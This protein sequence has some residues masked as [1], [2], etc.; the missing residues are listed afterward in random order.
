MNAL[1]ASPP[2]LV[3]HQHWRQGVDLAGHQRWGEAA[4]AFAR[5]T[6]VAP[7]DRV[8]WLNLANALR[9]SGALAR[10]V[11]AA[12]RCLQLEPGDP[13]ALRLVAECMAGMHR[14]AESVEAFALLDAGGN[15]DPETMVNHASAL[16]A[17]QQ[18]GEAAKVLLRALT[19]Q[20]ALVPAHLLLADACREQGLKREAV[21]CMKTVLALEPSNIQALANLSYEKRHLCDWHDYEQD[22]ERLR[23]DLLCAPVGLARIVSVFGL[24]SLPLPPDLQLV[25]ARGE[26]QAQAAGVRALPPVKPWVAGQ[27]RVRLGWLSYDFRD[28]PVSQLLHEM[29]ATIDRA[30]FEVVLYSIGPGDGSA[31]RAR[32]K[33]AADRFIDLGDVSDARAA[34]RI[35]SDGIDLLIDLMGHTRG[36]RLGIFAY[37]PAPVQA[38]F[39][40][41]PGSTG[42]DFIDYLI[43]DP[44]VTPL[45]AADHYS[46]KL[47]QMPLTFQP[48]GR[49][50]PLPQPMTRAEAGLPNDAFVMCA[51]N[52]PYKILPETFDIW[53]EVMRRVPKAVLWLR[54]TNTQLHEN[55]WREAAARGIVAE[56]VVFAK[57]VP[58]DRH[59]S[60]LALADVFVDTWPYNAHTTA[61]DALWAGVP[62]VTRYGESFASRVAASVLASVGLGEMAF[63][64]SEAYRLA[65]LALAMEPTLL[66]PYRRHLTEQRAALALFDTPRYTG[67][68]QEL[69]QRMVNRWQAGLAP[70]HLPAS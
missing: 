40:G 14:H 9:R 53:C 43:G 52:N 15:S 22:L 8:Y 54:E 41:Y 13:I 21:E 64:S 26:A 29:L 63:S 56:R 1:V 37:R 38:S 51:F 48:N 55:V 20:P 17:L 32:M 50:R 11:A 36:R 67:E 61:A 4:R 28:H 45:E 34:E 33:A 60:R 58:Y 39:L 69:L 46:E 7:H 66:A 49:G 70:E 30:R 23:D 3:G 44:V 68:L 10:A 57:A 2:N 24:L 12:R 27:R 6:R 59:F 18:P 25:A 42:A 16:L 62:V 47:A 35:R 31:M 19:L 65:I 5:A